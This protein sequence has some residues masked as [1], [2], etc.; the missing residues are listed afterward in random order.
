MNQD[1]NGMIGESKILSFSHEIHIRLFPVYTFKMM[2][3]SSEYD[4]SE[5]TDTVDTLVNDITTRLLRF[6]KFLNDQSKVN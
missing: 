3:L 6:G 1:P 5:P 4:S 2:N